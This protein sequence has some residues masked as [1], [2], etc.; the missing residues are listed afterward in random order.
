[1]AKKT[2]KK[3]AKKMTKKTTQKTP[4]RAAKAA[5]RRTDKAA[6]PSSTTKKSA[7][8]KA[9]K[10]V[11]QKPVLAAA[12]AVGDRVPAFELPA[13]GGKNVSLS[14]LQGKT[15]VLY[16]YPKDCTP[17]CTI[18]GH[19]FTRLHREFIA[20]GA[21]VFGISRDTLAL[22][23][24]FKTNEKYSF[25]LLSDTDEKVCQ[26]FGVM[27]LKNMYGKQVRGVERSTF[28]IAP[29]GRLVREWRG[30]KVDGHANEVLS[31]VKGLAV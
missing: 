27:K 30:V 24:K 15:V 1:M 14:Q 20:A 26:L 19:D 11:A 9:P 8:Q 17:G 23:E 21:E 31:F 10:T 29:D 25:D 3:T 22:H 28:V 7:Q 12:F 18:E 4:S 13:T 5:V 16:F 6:K 2:K